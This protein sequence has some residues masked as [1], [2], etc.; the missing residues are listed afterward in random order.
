[1]DVNFAV[2][3]DIDVDHR[4]QLLDVEAARGDVGGD[5]YRAAAI[6]ELHQHLVAFALFHLAMQG[7][8]DE[9]F[10]AQDLEQVA[11]LLAGIA[12]GQ[13]AD[14]AVMLEQ[15][16]NGSQPLFVGYFVEALADLAALV[17]FGQGDLLRLAQE[18]PRQGGDAF[19]KGGGEKQGLARLGAGLGDEGDVIVETHVEHA[20]GFVQHQ[21]IERG[22][23]EAHA[24][25]VVHDAPRRADH[26]MGAVLQ[27]GDLRPHGAAAAQGQHLDVVFAARQAANFLAHLVGQLPRWTQHQRLHREAARIQPRQQAQGKC[28]GLAAAGLG[29]RDQVVAGQ[30]QRQAGCLDRRHLQVAQLLQVH[31]RGRCQRQAGE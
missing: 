3:R 27:A 8:G 24:L 10:G 13:G 2:G 1:M 19:R 22:E 20:I 23:V 17:L 18:S 31:Q 16:R 11:A 29:L 30:G 5:Q 12:E 21:C 26:D 4:F 15:Q 25:Q 6:G 7:E 14:R 28:R 9:A